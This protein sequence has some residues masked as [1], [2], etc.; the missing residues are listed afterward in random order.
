MSGNQKEFS[1][2]GLYGKQCANGKLLNGSVQE[3]RHSQQSLTRRL[4]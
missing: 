2:Q 3:W 4:D 1:G